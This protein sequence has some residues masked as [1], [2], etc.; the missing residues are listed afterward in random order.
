MNE[1]TDRV[2]KEQ[3]TWYGPFSPVLNDFDER[4]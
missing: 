4:L 2:P 3:R 1:Q